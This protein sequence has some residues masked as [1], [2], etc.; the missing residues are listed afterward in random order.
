MCT[1]CGVALMSKG[2]ASGASGAKSKVAAGLLA[3]FVGSFGVHKF[4]LGYA[5]PGVIMLLVWLFGWLLL[6]IPSAIISL[7]ALIEGIMYL[8]KTDEQFDEQYVQNKKQWF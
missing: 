1:N 4:Y 3:I 2:G 6:G 5:V 7:I 8:T